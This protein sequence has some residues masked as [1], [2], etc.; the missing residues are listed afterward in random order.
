MAESADVVQ[1]PLDNGDA[2]E[3]RTAGGCGYL[4][5]PPTYG[6]GDDP[7]EPLPSLAELP[8][9]STAR[10]D[11]LRESADEIDRHRRGDRAE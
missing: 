7:G 6:G 11:R 8:E 4:M 9:N 3:L 1:I 10:L 5:F 2:V